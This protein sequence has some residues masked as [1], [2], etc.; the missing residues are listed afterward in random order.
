[1]IRQL[2]RVRFGGQLDT[3]MDDPAYTLVMK[4]LDAASL[5]RT[6]YMVAL[7]LWAAEQ[8]RLGETLNEAVLL[9]NLIGF[10]LGKADFKAALRNQFDPRAQEIL[11]RAIA[12]KLREAGGWVSANDL[13]RFI[14]DYFDARGL[15]HGA[16]DVLEEFLSCRLLVQRE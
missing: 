8:E 14:I 9:E 4:H 7:L 10:L 11:L 1:S 2:S 3:G 16:N 12:I 5:P 15:K 6:G 13:L